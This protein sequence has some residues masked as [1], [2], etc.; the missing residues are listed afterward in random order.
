MEKKLLKL[1]KLIC[2]GI[3]ALIF[4]WGCGKTADPSSPDSPSGEGQSESGDGQ[5]RKVNS[6]LPEGYV[7]S[8]RF[9]DAGG[10]KKTQHLL[11][12]T[13]LVGD[14]LYYC[15][16]KFSQKLQAVVSEV[17]VQERGEEPRLLDLPAE[18]DKLLSAIAVEEDGVVYL[19]YE[20]EGEDENIEAYILEKR[21]KKMQ[22]LYSVDTTT[23]IKEAA[24]DLGAEPTLNFLYLEAGSDG[25]LYAA[26]LEGVIVCW[27]QDGSYQDSFI[28]PRN[29]TTAMANEKICFGLANAGS[30]GVYAYWGGR[31]E[32]KNSCVHL[33]DLKKWLEMDDTERRSAPSLQVDFST[34]PESMGIGD[35][36]LFVFSGYEDGLYMTDQDR[37]WQI[38]LTDGS[39]EPLLL[40][41]DFTLKSGYVTE[42]RRRE[43]GGFLLYVFDSLEQENYWVILEPV[44]VDELAEKTE[45][46]L[47]IADNSWSSGASLL[48]KIDQVVLSYNRT[49]PNSHVTVKEY[50]EDSLTNLQ[51][52]LMNGKGPDILLERESFFDMETLMAKGAVEDLAPYLADGSQISGEDILP[53][54][55]DLITE[56]GRISRIPLSF[57]AGI[58]IL[59]K[60]K[61]GEIMTPEETIRFLA[62]DKHQYVDMFIWPDRF[63]IHLLSGAEMER[64]V[65]TDS[66]SCSFDSQEFVGLL[67]EA[68]E[69]ADKQMIMKR[70]DRF[71]PFRSGQLGAIVDDL[72]CM[73]D[74]L[75]IRACLSDIADIAGCPNS[76]R[77]LRYPAR[78]YDWLGINSASKH[79]DAAW[80]FVEFCLAYMSRSDDV[81]DRFAVTKDKFY[82][83]TLFAGDDDSGSLS[84]QILGNHFLESGYGAADISPVTQEETEFL[85]QLPEHL[86]LYED[87]DLLRVISEEAAAY[88]AGDISAEEAA[89][90]IQNRAALVLGE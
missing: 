7:L 58:M 20:K 26:T 39:V 83:Q 79:K 10:D 64:Y 5:T 75:C 38:S 19:L 61:A 24:A 48:D 76:R 73:G 52:E 63:L 60:D 14:S 18:E 43:D 2:F 84:Y 12:K 81:A 11:H 25:K 49:H 4:L 31:D 86:Y 57:S 72:N 67:E 66:K 47:G 40:W 6:A 70:S 69:L 32:A 37:L 28:L 34:A 80:G 13:H 33:Y 59:P 82:R 90:R 65:D 23:D 27:D 35:G 9:E 88:F 15:F 68:A 50:A 51:L 89:K 16:R 85:R 62:Q 56:N 22:L 71:E 8:A 87:Q 3:M 53:G 29:G 36:D 46:V 21:D 45:L 74:Y 41:Q 77:E 54:I 42:I 17:Y 1:R 78:L 55:L 30:S 44:S